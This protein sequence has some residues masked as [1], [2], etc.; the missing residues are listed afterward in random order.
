MISL[1]LSLLVQT[2]AAAE[3]PKRIEA[4]ARKVFVGQ[5]WPGLVL[6]ISPPDGSIQ[7]IA[8]GERKIG[9][10]SKLLKTDR[11][12][13]GSGAKALTTAILHQLMEQPKYGIQMN[14]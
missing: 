6:S 5:K 9:S 4:S 14:S 3:F 7:T 10:G 2:A 8:M 1:F 12:P 13:I 11:F